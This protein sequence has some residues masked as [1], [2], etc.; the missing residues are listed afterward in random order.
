M[1]PAPVPPVSPGNPRPAAL[2]R[3]AAAAPPPPWRLRWLLAAPH[4]L[5]FAAGALMLGASALWWALV[6][7][8][9]ARGVPLPWQL[10]PAQAHALL[11]VFGFMPQFF[12]GFLFTAG[13]R[14]LALPPPDARTLLA[15]V[16][17][18]LVGWAVFLPGVHA[19]TAALGTLLCAAGLAA[20]A[21][22]W[23]LFVLRFWRLLRA[24]RVDDRLHLRCVAGALAFGALLLWAAA[25]A[26][27]L[28]HTPW[29]RPLALAGVWGFAGVVFVSAAHR[30][31]PFFGAAALPAL[32]AWRPSGLLAVFVGAML[33]E[34]AAHAAQALW[35]PWPAAAHA[36]LAALEA[37]LALLLLVLAWRWARQARLRQRLLAMLFLGFLWLGVALALAAASNALAAAG[38]GSLGLAPLHA[39]TMGFL[40]STLLAMVTR[41]T[42][43]HGGRALAADDVAW[44][45]FLALQ[46]AVLLRLGA[47]LLPALAGVLTPAAAVSWAAVTGAWALR[48]GRWYGRPRIDGRPG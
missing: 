5:A 4:R 47:E 41:V 17:A 2:R 8:A 14:W 11:M 23:S 32:E 27:A 16:L 26:V 46:G 18:Q 6:L 29:L 21:L 37:A 13:P 28:Q 48:Y 33:V 10:A 30:M 44:A 3:A 12:A 25:A 22:G 36:L 7:L 38:G 24:S 31:V 1:S 40:G 15:P 9:R 43:G 42:S 19:P 45:L 35:W 20:V 39:F 34:A